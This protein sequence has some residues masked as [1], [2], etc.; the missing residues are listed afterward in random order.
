MQCKEEKA[1]IEQIRLHDMRE[2]FQDKEQENAEFNAMGKCTVLKTKKLKE[3]RR[4]NRFFDTDFVDRST[5][6]QIAEEHKNEDKSSS[7]KAS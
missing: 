2:T 6:D 7:T 4:R 1:L 5:L 3:I